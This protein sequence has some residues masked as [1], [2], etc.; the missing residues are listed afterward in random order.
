MSKIAFKVNIT[1]AEALEQVK[2]YQTGAGSEL[3]HEELYDLGEGKAIGTL[4]FQ[5][6]YFRAGNRAALVVLADNL[7]GYSEVRTIATGSSQGVFINFDWG[8]ADDYAAS[9]RKALAAHIIED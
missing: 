2:K 1:P 5:K 8:A 9:V 4:V 6:Y 7:K 3:I